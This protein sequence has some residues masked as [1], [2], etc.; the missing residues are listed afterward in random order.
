VLI[1]HI[2]LHKEAGFCFDGPLLEESPWS[3]VL[4]QNFISPAATQWLLEHL[5]PVL[6]LNG[7]DH[8]GCVYF[9]ETPDQRIPEYTLRSIMG[10]YGGHLLLVDVIPTSETS[11]DGRPVF[12]YRV[13]DIPFISIR[14]IVVLLVAWGL[15]IALGLVLYWCQ[16]AAQHAP[17]FRAA[18]TVSSKIE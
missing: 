15:L 10:E 6:I 3:G 4:R 12:A 5:R 14:Y 9:H 18:A 7:H 13:S 1:K 17:F 2:P 8:E 11:P 16:P